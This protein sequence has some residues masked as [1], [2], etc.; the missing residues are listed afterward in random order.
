LSSELK[1]KDLPSGHDGK[2]YISL[3][4]DRVDAFY[5]KKISAKLEPI[6]ENSR[7]LGQRMTQNALRGLKGTGD[8]TY[9][10]TTPAF[11]KAYR[12][13]KNGGDAPDIDLQYYSDSPTDAFDRI[14]VSLSGVILANV[15]MGALD[16]SNDNAQT[17]D[18]TFT[19]D[20][21]DLI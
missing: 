5:I 1:V 15:G 16:D 20:D 4:G 6:V 13:Y 7:P 11:I 14:E 12:N 18:S 10:N 17:Q 8:L 19:F 21:F 2:A 3:N 9:C